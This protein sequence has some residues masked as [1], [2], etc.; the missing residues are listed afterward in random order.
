M[1]SAQVFA[2]AWSGRHVD[3][4]PRAKGGH[5][6]QPASTV[7]A[8]TASETGNCVSLRREDQP[9]PGHVR[10]G[11][12]AMDEQHV[13]RCVG[14]DVVAVVPLTRDVDPSLDQVTKPGIRKCNAR[15]AEP[16]D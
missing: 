8:I 14:G 5:Q 15:Y 7:P 3:F 13:A 11:I 4:G 16:G 9:C 12:V 6:R 1:W 2:R 10:N